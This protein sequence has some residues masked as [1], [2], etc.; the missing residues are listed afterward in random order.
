MSDRTFKEIFRGRQSSL[1]DKI[2]I[3]HGLL[4][5]LV[6]Y[7]VIT[8]SHKQDIKVRAVTVNVSQVGR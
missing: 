7:R 8:A 5:K 4:T 1:V 2:D 6:D 3:D